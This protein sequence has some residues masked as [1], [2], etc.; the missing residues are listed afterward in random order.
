MHRQVIDSQKAMEDYCLK[1]VY[2]TVYLAKAL[3]FEVL[4]V[5]GTKAYKCS[6]EE[7]S[8]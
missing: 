4:N 3:E 2:R 1:G 6:E 5:L 8:R 7:K